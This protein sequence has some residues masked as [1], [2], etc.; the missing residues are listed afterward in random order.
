MKLSF[1]IPCYGSE[2]TIKQVTD[3]IERTVQSLKKY[4]YEIVLVN[5]CSPDNVWSEIKNIAKKNT[6]VRGLCLAR[7]FGQ[8]AAL[9]AGYK[10]CTGDYI[11]SLDDDGQ[12]PLDSLYK[13]L[14][15]IESGYDVVYAYYKEIKRGFFRKFGT[16]M[17]DLLSKSMLNAPDDLKG[18][19]FYVARKFVIDEMLR[20]ENSYPYLA[21]L[22]LRT[23]KNIACVE[24]EHRERIQGQSGYSFKKLLA[25][26][27]NGFTA[28]SVKPLEIS[29][30]LGA[31]FS[32]L[33]FIG[34]IINIVMHI[35]INHSD[36]AMW[37]ILGAIFFVGG[38]V[39][40]MIGIVGEYVGRIYMCMNKAPQYVIR[41]TTEVI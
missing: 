30:I 12:V 23:T 11:V 4:D 17:S 22:V 28:F 15:K 20:Y 9:L 19:S 40:I 7:N 37:M 27:I 41:E 10:V 6:K 29:V 2:K 24:V 5:D 13:L 1:V 26:W 14:E 16:W 3:E 18:S 32:I 36:F 38:I 25:L 39:L 21:G 33:S 31:A 35:Y 8:H 34:M